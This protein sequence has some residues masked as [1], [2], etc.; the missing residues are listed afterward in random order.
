[1]AGGLA[2]YQKPARSEAHP[3]QPGHRPGQPK[4]VGLPDS[5]GLWKREPLFVLA[6]PFQLERDLN[7]FD[8]EARHAFHDSVTAL[9]RN[10]ANRYG[11]GAV[12]PMADQR[13]ENGRETC[14]QYLRSLLQV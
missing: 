9:I 6:L 13:N 12:Q 4:G 14:G 1:V 2:G 7:A 3:C 8:T 5:L 11:R 10:G